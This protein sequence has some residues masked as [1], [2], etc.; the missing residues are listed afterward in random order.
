[1]R[2]STI[3]AA[4]LLTGLA[5]AASTTA[6]TKISRAYIEGGM[7]TITPDT[8]LSGVSIRNATIVLDNNARKENVSIISTEFLHCTFVPSLV[9]WRG[10]VN[11]QD[12][13]I[14]DAK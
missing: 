1:M 4:M 7:I 9:V 8:V 5:G 3:V 11:M 12:V 10:F 13:R 2:I 14:E 6:Q